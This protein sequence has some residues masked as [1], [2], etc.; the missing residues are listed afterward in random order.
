MNLKGIDQ[1]ACGLRLA[2]LGEARDIAGGVITAAAD[3]RERKSKALWTPLSEGDLVLVR[4]FE[5]TINLRRKLDAEWEGP[6]W[7]VDIS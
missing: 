2:N 1:A 6:F 3:A 4:N 7:L 5:V